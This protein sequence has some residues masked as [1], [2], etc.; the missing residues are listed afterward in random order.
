MRDKLLL[1]AV[2]ALSPVLIGAVALVHGS[3]LDD[4]TSSQLERSTDEHR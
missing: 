3:R 1:A 2:L 4:T